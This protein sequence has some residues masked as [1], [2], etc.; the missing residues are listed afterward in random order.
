MKDARLSALKAL[1]EATDKGQFDQIPSFFTPSCIWTVRPGAV[2]Q[3]LPNEG[4]L[5]VEEHVGVLMMTK[6]DMLAE[7]K[8][9]E[10]HKVI[11]GA[12]SLTAHVTVHGITRDHHP[13]DC[14]CVLMLEYEH[15]TTK[16][17]SGMELLDS[18]YVGAHFARLNAPA[19]EK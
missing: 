5:S 11:H 12:N 1:F 13:Y 10:I 16:I 14:E 6:R 19:E 18:A 8:G 17:S 2:A 7:P 9:L 4:K 3:F 15:G